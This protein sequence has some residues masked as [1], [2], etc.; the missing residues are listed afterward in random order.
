MH[1][2]TE[3]L[4]IIIPSFPLDS[5]TGQ[6]FP[7]TCIGLKHVKEH[8]AATQRARPLT[9]EQDVQASICHFSPL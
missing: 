2:R 4:H 1:D 9:H 7:S 6:H 8:V 5:Q 3:V